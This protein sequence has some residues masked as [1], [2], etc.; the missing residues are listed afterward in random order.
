M[1]AE[2]AGELVELHALVPDHAPAIVRGINASLDELSPWFPWAQA[3][4]TEADQITRATAAQRAALEG[5][6]FEYSVVER[7]G[8]ALV[9]G[10][11][12]NPRVA[13]GTAEIGYWIR[14]DRHGR[15]YATDAVRAAVRCCIDALPGVQRI[16]IHA[17][18]LNEPSNRVAA[19]A[20]FVWSRRT[21]R[22]HAAPG[23]SGLANVWTLGRPQI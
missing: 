11:R 15:G 14:S 9:G 22:E 17:D 2:C 5:R 20:G 10:L 8:G 13:D 7:S 21:E 16:E 4:A 23:H 3:P 18:V 12:V 19:K 1:P 6:D